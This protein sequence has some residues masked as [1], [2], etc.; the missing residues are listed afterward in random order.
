ML[1]PLLAV[2]LAVRQTDPYLV[3]PPKPAPTMDEPDPAG[4]FK[5]TWDSLQ[6][7]YKSPAW[8]RDAKFGIW[9]HWTAQ[10]VPEQGDWY[11]QRMYV[12][13]D[14][15]YDYQVAHYG[16]PSKV[17]FKDI[18]H[19]WHAENWH[20]DE[21]I[22]LYKAAGAHYFVAL[23]NHHDNFDTWDSKYQPWNSVNIGPHR[24]IVGEW[25]Q[26]ARKNGLR[27]GVTVHAARS[28]DWFSVS[29]ESDKTG[30]LAGVPYDGRLTAAEGVGQWWQG[31]DPADLYSPDGP[32]RTPEARK[33]YERKFYN[34]VMDLTSTYHPDLLY[35]DDG[36][37]PTRYGLEIAANYYNEN[38]NWHRG[39]LQAVLNV[40]SNEARIKSAMVL[41]YERGRSDAISPNPWQ[42]D[43]CIGDWHYDE[44]IF[45]EHRYKTAD[46]VIKMLADI[47]SKNGNLLLNIPLPGDG[48]PD[49]DEIAF[50][51]QMADWMKINQLAIFGTRPWTIAGE[52]PTRM[53][54]GGFSEGGESK[55]GA[56]DFRFTTKGSTLYAIAMAWPDRGTYTVRTLASN[57][58]GI[59][60]NV[61]GVHL[62]GWKEP[63]KWTCDSDGLHVTLPP[64][65]PCEH[66]YALKI[67]G[68]KVAES[69]PM[70]LVDV[71]IVAKP[72]P[73]GNIQLIPDNATLKGNVQVQAGALANIGYWDNPDDT[74]SWQVY[75]PAAG[76]YD[77]VTHVA[78]A[79]GPTSFVVDAGGEP[80]QSIIAP[81]TGDWDKFV[82]IDAPGLVVTKPGIA[83]VTV[84]A[85]DRG[86]WHPMNLA[87]IVLKRRS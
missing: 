23:A 9:A 58:P 35:F 54:G 74:V 3:K 51:H 42:T 47:V 30:P 83:T 24:D 41:D 81:E 79:G 18:D 72:D 86:S 20:P 38:M 52:G 4:P 28:W 26:I 22:K 34:R 2:A 7:G 62:L 57:A 49:T 43:T 59:V 85:A 53:R 65:K 73:E 76:L 84:K 60:G 82:E 21:L 29:H 15:D 78:T 45:H 19:I 16:H 80:T 27:F 77:I 32:A 33:A 13:G 63:L 48:R 10:C 55:L 25:A 11:A 44:R 68:L 12:Q 56:S 1:F 75:F 17:G 70:P 71:A 37:P 66:A 39:Q 6:N 64:Q 36:E 8:F 67:D 31:Y 50:L 61:T 87:A 14:H 5:P 46:Q 40:K 69:H